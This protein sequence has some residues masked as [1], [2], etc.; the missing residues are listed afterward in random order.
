MTWSFYEKTSRVGELVD[1]L[2]KGTPGAGHPDVRIKSIAETV[3][4]PETG[5]GLRPIP[6]AH[7]ES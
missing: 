4:R 3:G 5:I 1:G 2:P 7:G 6:H